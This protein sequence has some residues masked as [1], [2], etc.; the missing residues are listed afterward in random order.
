MV[1]LVELDG[2]TPLAWPELHRR[3]AE[4]YRPRPSYVQQRVLAQMVRDVWYSAYDLS[5]VTGWNQR[6]IKAAL[7]GLVGLGYVE[8]EYDKYWRDFAFRLVEQEEAA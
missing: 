4:Y 2:V 3:V 6:S 8:Q 5:V 7:E 1:H